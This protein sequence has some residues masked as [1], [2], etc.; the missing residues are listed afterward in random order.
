M[1][2]LTA[3]D[4]DMLWS[5]GYLGTSNP[6]QLL[7][8]VVF[9]VGKGC[10]LR[11]GKEHRASHGLPFNSQF[12]FMHD[13]D[14]EYYLRYT[15]DIGLKTN[16]GGLKQKKIQPKQVDLYTTDDEERCPLHVILKYL[17]L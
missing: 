11:M 1:E 7:N 13:S 12:C 17:S 9:I 14:G 6:T 16:K 8:T 10:A 2:I 15:E 5:Q 4:E 3:T